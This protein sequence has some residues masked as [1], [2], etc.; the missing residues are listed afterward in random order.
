MLLGVFRACPRRQDMRAAANRHCLPLFLFCSGS[1]GGDGAGG[2]RRRVVVY[3]QNLDGMGLLC[4][5][6]IAVHMT[7]LTDGEIARLAETSSNVVHCPTSNLKLAS[8]R[9]SGVHARAACC[10]VATLRVLRHAIVRPVLLLHTLPR[11]D[12]VPL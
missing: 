6:M 11:R 1:G 12:V 10:V 7:Q 4:D 8:G 9:R 5:K 2:I 3:V